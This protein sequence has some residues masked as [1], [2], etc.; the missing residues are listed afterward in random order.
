MWLLLVLG[1]E[2]PGG[3]QAVTQG[4]LLLVLG[5]GPLSKGTGHTEARCCWF[6]VCEPLRHLGKPTA[7]AKIGCLYGKTF[8]N[9]FNGP[10]SWMG[11]SL[12]DS[13]GRDKLF[14]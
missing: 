10:A 6:G 1:S 4:Q 8:D 12:G 14:P 3:G 7:L 11:H 9:G 13:P 2:V 5:L